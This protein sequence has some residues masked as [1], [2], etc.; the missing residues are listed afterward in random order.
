[1]G[2]WIWLPGRWH[3]RRQGSRCLLLQHYDVGASYLIT[4]TKP[5][6]FQ[7]APAAPLDIPAANA[8]AIGRGRL[9][10]C[11]AAI[12]A[13]GRLRVVNLIHRRRCGETP[14]MIPGR[15]GNSSGKRGE[16]PV[17]LATALAKANRSTRRFVGHHC[18]I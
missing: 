7:A 13:R 2:G 4:S 14:S 11:A 8:P 6:R 18:L 17:Q 3:A 15:G 9:L 12:G 1:M 16:R 10:V 5:R